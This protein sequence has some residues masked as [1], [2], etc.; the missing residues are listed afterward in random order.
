MARCFLVLVLTALCRAVTISVTPLD[1]APALS[2][3]DE[4]SL[5]GASIANTFGAS[6]QMLQSTERSA[7][8]QMLQ[9]VERSVNQAVVTAVADAKRYAAKVTE[10][11]VKKVKPVNAAIA[12]ADGA[13]LRE[14][15]EVR[16]QKALLLQNELELH[17]QQQLQETDD[18][19]P[20][21]IREE[22][23]ETD[24]QH[25]E[26]TTSH[27]TADP[28][29]D[30]TQ[31]GQVTV[32]YSPADQRPVD[33]PEKNAEKEATARL[34][35]AMDEVK[36]SRISRNQAAV[37]EANQTQNAAL[38]EIKAANNEAL[39]EASDEKWYEHGSNAPD[40]S[41]TYYAEKQLN[42]T[43]V[44]HD[45]RINAQRY[46]GRSTANASNVELLDFDLNT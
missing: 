11:E 6:D 13:E 31:A 23:R 44:N 20:S 24:E 16:E 36:E 26:E 46:G 2:L 18:Q 17:K 19:T 1:S 30:A 25:Q 22:L 12:T 9:S 10:A 37:N 28:A 43:S 42:A 38:A 32:N 29:A 15:V 7:T 4:E 45:D 35:A 34:A 33:D 27:S 40:P 5:P 21:R 39:A 41:K 14:E 8:G 3:V